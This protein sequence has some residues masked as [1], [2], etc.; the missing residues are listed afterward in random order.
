MCA[1]TVTEFASFMALKEVA[2]TVEASA[3]RK[4]NAKQGR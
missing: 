3:E 1:Y 4:R 2:D